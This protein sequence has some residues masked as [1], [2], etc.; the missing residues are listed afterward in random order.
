MKHLSV[1]PLTEEGVGM[2]CD[3]LRRVGIPSRLASFQAPPL[4]AVRRS[5]TGKGLNSTMIVSL[6]IL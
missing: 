6:R 2:L 3:G 4:I 1:S 5:V